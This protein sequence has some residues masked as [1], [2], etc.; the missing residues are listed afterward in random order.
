MIRFWHFDLFVDS[1]FY[2]LVSQRVV[3][4]LWLFFLCKNKNFLILMCWSVSSFK[5][6]HRS[7]I[8]V[9][10]THGLYSK[11][12]V[13]TDT[14]LNCYSPSSIQWV[15]LQWTIHSESVS[16]SD[17]TDQIQRMIRSWIRYWCFSYKLMNTA[18]NISL[19]VSVSDIEIQNTSLLLFTIHYDCTE[20]KIS[21]F[22]P[23]KKVSH[24]ISYCCHI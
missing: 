20:N 11:M 13:R 19:H 22:V 16:T 18:V 17:W 8:T 1:P 4:N 2:H 7:I 9:H 14:H 12:C 15:K 21:S 10:V 6:W 5:K 3:S 23:Q 24:V